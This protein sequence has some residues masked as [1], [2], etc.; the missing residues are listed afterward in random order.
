MKILEK[1][2]AEMR[3]ELSKYPSEVLSIS[4][5][6]KVLSKSPEIFQTLMTNIK[7]DVDWSKCNQDYKHIEER[8]TLGIYL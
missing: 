2:A 3:V 6:I 8:R 5:K 1:S 7:P 4:D